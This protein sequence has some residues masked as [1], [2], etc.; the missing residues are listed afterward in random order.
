MSSRISSTKFIFQNA[1]IQRHRVVISLFCCCYCWRWT[2]ASVCLFGSTVSS[3][4][5]RIGESHRVVGLGGWGK[6]EDGRYP[7]LE[8][9]DWILT[10]GR[11]SGR[12]SNIK[13][14]HIW[15]EWPPFSITIL[16]WN[17]FQ[18]KIPIRPSSAI[19]SP[20]QKEEEEEEEGGNRL[21][22]N[23]DI[24]LNINRSDL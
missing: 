20:S 1:R 21:H 15:N 9:F 16:A 18:L 23:M 12:G 7:W 5:K 4:H 2:A 24:W 14:C 19:T 17:V 22:L 10:N 11:V 8:I 13:R 6:E 3:L